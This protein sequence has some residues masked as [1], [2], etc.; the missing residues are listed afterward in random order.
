MSII[1]NNSVIQVNSSKLSKGSPKMPAHDKE[2]AYS[3]SL[4]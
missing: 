4:V 2:Q 3:H 1:N